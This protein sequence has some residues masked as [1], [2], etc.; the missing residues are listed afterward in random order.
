MPPQPLNVNLFRV[1]MALA[2]YP[3]EISL[4]DQFDQEAA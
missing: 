3:L 4:D 1:H 2:E